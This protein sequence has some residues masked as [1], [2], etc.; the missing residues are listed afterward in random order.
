MCCALNYELEPLHELIIS[1]TDNGIPS[2]TS[3]FTLL[4]H[5]ENENDPPHSMMITNN[6]VREDTAIGEHVAKLTVVDEDDDHDIVF[7]TKPGEDQY[8]SIDNGFVVLRRQLDFEFL[9]IVELYVM[10]T[11]NGSPPDHVCFT[12]LHFSFQMFCF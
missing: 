4:I 8:F 9:P 2:L 3:I 6:H 11:D 10:A 5:V 7:T 1:I 12:P